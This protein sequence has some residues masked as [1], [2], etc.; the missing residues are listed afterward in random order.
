MTEYAAQLGY[1]VHIL[2]NRFHLLPLRTA[3]RYRTVSPEKQTV[4]YKTG[5]H[6]FGQDS[7]NQRL[8]RKTVWFPKLWFFPHTKDRAFCFLFLEYWLMVVL[9]AQALQIHLGKPLV[10]FIIPPSSGLCI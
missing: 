7:R 9:A 5:I 10:C 1:F 3:A 2:L 6:A 8:Y 4:R